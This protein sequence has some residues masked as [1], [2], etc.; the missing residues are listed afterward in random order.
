MLSRFIA[1]TFSHVADQVAVCSQYGHPDEIVVKL[2][3]ALIQT[4]LEPVA[5]KEV[6]TSRYSHVVHRSNRLDRGFVLLYILAALHSPES[7]ADIMSA[8][9]A[10]PGNYLIHNSSPANELR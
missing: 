3:R 2:R 4:H 1:V 6:R 10:K 8:Y 7:E 5:K 9:S